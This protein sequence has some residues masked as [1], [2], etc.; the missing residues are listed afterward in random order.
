MIKEGE[1]LGTIIEEMNMTN[2]TS[3]RHFKDFIRKREKAAGKKM[4][5]ALQ[6]I[7]KELKLIGHSNK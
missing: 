6:L 5:A 2:E 1:K 7:W 4:P 3:P